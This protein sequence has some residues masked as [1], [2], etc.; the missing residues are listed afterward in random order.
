MNLE[1]LKITYPGSQAFDDVL[2]NDKRQERWAKERLEQGFDETE[3]WNLDVALAHIILP[4]LKAYKT[5]VS[6]KID[7]KRLDKVIKA[8][9]LVAN[10]KGVLFSE[11]ELKTIKKGLTIFAEDLMTY[12]I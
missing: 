2:K 10:C 5:N 11:K 3:L 7:I 12:W 1:Q 4:R 8:F 9:E 6:T